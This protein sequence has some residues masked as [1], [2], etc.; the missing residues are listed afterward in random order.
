MGTGLQR[1]LSRNRMR[2][3]RDNDGDGYATLSTVRAIN[4]TWRERALDKAIHM[5]KVF[6][7]KYAVQA[8]F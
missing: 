8:R 7:R 1:V 2:R 3:R 4:T 5:K 6:F